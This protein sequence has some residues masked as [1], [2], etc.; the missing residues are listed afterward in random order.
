MP[1][2]DYAEQ[3]A[4]AWSLHRQGKNDDA[5]REFNALLQQ[6]ANN[7]DALYGLGLAQRSVG[8]AETAKATFERCLAQLDSATDSK[9]AED[10]YQMLVRM[11]GQRISELASV[12]S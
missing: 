2:Q 5:I 7:I 12:L 1:S 11:V 4:R 6:S 9:S 10:R 3:F 8:Q